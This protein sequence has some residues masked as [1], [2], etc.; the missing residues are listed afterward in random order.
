MLYIFLHM[1]V[2]A[3]VLK[4]GD[5]MGWK[6]SNK[7]WKYKLFWKYLEELSRLPGR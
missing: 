5:K 3:Y 7:I 1:C 2:Y 4:N 6:L